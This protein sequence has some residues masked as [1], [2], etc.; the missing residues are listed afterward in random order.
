MAKGYVNPNI[1]ALI[2]KSGEVASSVEYTNSQGIKITLKAV[3]PYL[4]QSVRASV[5]YPEAPTY[6]VQIAGSEEFEVHIHDED[7]IAQSGEEERAKWTAYKMGIAEANE[8]SSENMLNL[9]LMEGVICEAPDLTKF[10]KKMKI[11]GVETPTDE[12]EAELFWKR[13]YVI[14]SATD[15]EVI[16]QIVLSLSGVSSEEVDSMK[17]TFQD[18]VEP[19]A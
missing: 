10:K 15:A 5:K 6:Q 7:S 4:A 16:T 18:T 1:Q 2:S 12:D 3:P 9:I 19:S 8:R 13:L 14:G 17:G 11:L